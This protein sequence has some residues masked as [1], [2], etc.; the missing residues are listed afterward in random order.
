LPETR[1]RL[2]G[3]VRSRR[4]AHRFSCYWPA[5]FSVWRA[6][7]SEPVNQIAESTENIVV[8]F[9]WRSAVRSRK[10]RL[11]QSVAAE[12]SAG[13]ERKGPAAWPETARQ[14]AL[15]PILQRPSLRPP[16]P[17]VTLEAGYPIALCNQEPERFG[18]HVRP[19]PQTFSQA[20][21]GEIVGFPVQA[22]TSLE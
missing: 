8:T 19:P 4:G 21:H 2:S 14:P 16:D 3:G 9:L 11:G 15:G 7:G 18:V 22:A 12:A 10:F 17:A 5:E 1:D 6:S 13:H 20:E